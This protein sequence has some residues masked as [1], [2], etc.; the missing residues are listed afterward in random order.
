M[1]ISELEA[2]RE[3]KNRE[4]VICD[5][6]E[7]LF[8]CLLLEAAKGRSHAS[9]KYWSMRSDCDLLAVKKDLTCSPVK[10]KARLDIPIEL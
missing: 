4:H 6:I 7:S 9:L 1:S 3:G 8:Y 10:F 2:L 5:D